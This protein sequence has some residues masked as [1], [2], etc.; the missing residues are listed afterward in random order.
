MD[1]FP[2]STQ[3]TLSYPV[4]DLYKWEHTTCDFKNYEPMVKITKSVRK[5]FAYIFS[6]NK[7][8]LIKLLRKHHIPLFTIKNATD[9]EVESYHIVH[10]TS[11]VD[12]DK[13]AISIDLRKEK[14]IKTY[15][16]GDVVIKL[17]N[18]AANLIP[19]LLELESNWG[20]VTKRGGGKYRFK[21]YLKENSLYPIS[22]IPDAQELLLEVY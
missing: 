11:G 21:D 9:I 8:K 3:K 18:A 6:A 17:N 13:P 19:L 22:R 12:E 10:I 15:Q 4:F 20:I 16:S 1:Y 14:S 7:K 5:P 2:D